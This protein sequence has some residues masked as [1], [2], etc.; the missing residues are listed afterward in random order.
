M[1]SGAAS[2][3]LFAVCCGEDSGVRADLARFFGGGRGA[4][5]LGGWG[6]EGPT[7]GGHRAAKSRAASFVLFGTGCGEDSG[8]TSH[9]ARFFGAGRGVALGPLGGLGRLG[10]RATG[11]R[12]TLR[13]GS[14]DVD[15]PLD[16]SGSAALS[17]SV[18]IVALG[19]RRVEGPTSG[20]LLPVK[21]GAASFVLFAISSGEDSGVRADRVRFFGAGRGAA[22]KTLGG[23]WL[24]GKQTVGVAEQGG[25]WDV[26]V[27][28][29]CRR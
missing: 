1:K 26:P 10:K 29:D 17:G 18:R 13:P 16:L 25:G 15:P 11:L 28:V 2:F 19:G 23:L 5:L 14:W 27:Q 9:L 4:V 21:S 22:L 3:V 7:S 24:L 20:G 6:V 12:A 8:V